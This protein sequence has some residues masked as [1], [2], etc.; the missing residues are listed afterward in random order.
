MDFPHHFMGSGNA[1]DNEAAAQPPTDSNELEFL[2][3]QR[4]VAALQAAHER[5]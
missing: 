3:Q 1:D 2:E 4:R 5:T